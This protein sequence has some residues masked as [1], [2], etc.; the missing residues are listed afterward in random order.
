MIIKDVVILAAGVG[1]RLRP[2]TNIM[3]KCCVPVSNKSLIRR[4]VEQLQEKSPNIHIYV[5]SGYLGDI[6]CEEVSVF[7]NTVSVIKNVNFATTNNMESCRI[8]FEQI[9][10]SKPVM[11]INGDCI[12]ADE[13]IDKMVNA[14]GNFIGVDRSDYFEES[15]KP[16][17]S[18][19]N[20]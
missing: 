4:L 17:L 3:P 5:A 12:Y 11:I 1:L 7:G 18:I 9:D 10:F 6:L 16:F 19:F 8:V 14:Q 13:I 15:M 20:K 2:L